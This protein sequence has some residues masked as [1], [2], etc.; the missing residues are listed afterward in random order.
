MGT[1]YYLVLNKEKLLIYVGRNIDRENF[2]SDLEKF[3]NFFNEEF[4]DSDYDLLEK[5][6]KLT[7][8]DFKK[9]ISTYELAID[10]LSTKTKNFALLSLAFGRLLKQ[11]NKEIKIISNFEQKKYKKY[12]IV[13]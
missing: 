9:V 13:G 10:M 11:D 4:D 12:K 8:R 1:H 6:Y 5:P 2:E 3:C 7:S